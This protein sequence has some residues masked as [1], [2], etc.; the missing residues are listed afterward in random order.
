MPILKPKAPQ[1]SKATFS[2]H[3][4]LEAPQRFRAPLI[5]ANLEPDSGPQRSRAT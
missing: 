1:R 2:T 4:K 5:S 3:L